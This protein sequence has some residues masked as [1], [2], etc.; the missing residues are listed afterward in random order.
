[1]GA[2][3]LQF[4]VST[5]QTQSSKHY[6][7]FSSQVL[8][9]DI[10]ISKITKDNFSSEVYQDKAE[11]IFFCSLCFFFCYYIVLCLCLCRCLCHT[12]HCISLFCLFVSLVFMPLGFILPTIAHLFPQ[13]IHMLLTSEE[14]NFS[15][16]DF[17]L[18][19]KSDS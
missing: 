9:S 8:T 5:L 3:L 19:I 18:D 11:R 14:F 13:N 15:L 12:L 1:M 6:A 2:I 7:K 17:K 16:T 4:T 10:S